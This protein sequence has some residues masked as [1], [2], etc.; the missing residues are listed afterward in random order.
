MKRRDFLACAVTALVPA[1]GL[2]AQILADDR[3]VAYGTANPPW[4]P[5]LALRC[6][7]K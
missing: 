5:G 1:P 6:Q 4:R 3:I 2:H 7:L